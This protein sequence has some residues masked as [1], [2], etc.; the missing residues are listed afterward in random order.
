MSLDLPL[1]QFP[2]HLEIKKRKVL[3]GKKIPSHLF[4][5]E[6]GTFGGKYFP[7]FRRILDFHT[8][9][10]LGLRKREYIQKFCKLVSFLKNVN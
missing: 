9:S 1:L 2:H 8:K 3:Q 4:R 5:I 7:P 10:S 6:E